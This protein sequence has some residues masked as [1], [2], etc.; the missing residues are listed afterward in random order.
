M[1]VH[2][3]WT[4]DAVLTAFDEHLRRT[5]GTCLE[6]RR[7]YARL[8]RTFLE[9]VFEDGPPDL[10]RVSARDVIRFVSASTARYRPCT[11]KLVA[12]AMRSF[13]RFLR[14]E[15]WREDRLEDAVPTVPHR[16]HG[17]LPRHLGE[18]EFVRLLVSL[19]V[20]SPRAL[21]DKAILLCLA[22]LGLR[23]SEVARLRLDDVDWRAGTVCIRTRKTGRGA[24]LPLPRDLGRALVAYLR[25]G[26]PATPV[27]Q[28]FV[29]HWMRVGEPVNRQLVGDAVKR[30]LR[31]AGISAPMRGANLLRHSLGSSLLRHG[32]TLKEIA[33][34]FGH[35]S[36]NTTTIY[37]KVDVAALREVALPWPEVAP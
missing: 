17:S 16:R 4:P 29:L 18:R 6:A 28:V 8:V 25:H 19:D 10:A 3:Q 11:V 26:R 27:R 12:T 34:L 21:R 30:A 31:H 23:A 9:S 32:A 13:F 5:R 15:G 14:A 22:R 37:A 24:V 7:N 20:S 33:D 2:G 36:L 1:A 35:R